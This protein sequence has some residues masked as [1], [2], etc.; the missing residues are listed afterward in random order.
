MVNVTP[1]LMVTSPTTFTVS[2]SQVVAAAM[3]PLTVIFTALR[4]AAEKRIN[5]NNTKL[6]L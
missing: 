4:L 3:A 2:A 1:L 6:K 5:S